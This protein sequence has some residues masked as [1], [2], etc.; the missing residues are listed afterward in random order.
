MFNRSQGDLPMYSSLNNNGNAN[1]Y[2]EKSFHKTSSS[3]F[4]SPSS[5]YA[6]AARYLR[7]ILQDN[8]TR[9]VFF[10][11][12][13]NLSFTVVEALW[14]FWTNSLGLTSDAVHMLFDS[15]A[16][17][18]SLIASVIAKWE[19]NER[20]TYG[21]G[22]VE[23]LTGF[24]NAILLCYASIQI[25][26]EAFERM[27]DPPKLETDQLL[28]V[29]ILGLIVNLVGIFAFD[30]GHMHGHSHGESN[31][32]SHSHSHDWGGGHSHGHSHH[33]HES[34]G[35][36]MHSDN[37]LLEGM[38]LHILS[39]TLGSVGVIVSTLLIRYFDWYWSDPLCSIFIGILTLL[40]VWALLRDSA[41][42]LCQRV[43]PKFE[44]KTPDLYRA[45]MRIDGVVGCSS[46]HF[47][48][49]STGNYVGT[50]KVQVT[51][52]ANE[53]RTRLLVL[54]AGQEILGL[55][56]MTVQIEKDQVMNL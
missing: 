47:W 28:I 17:L 30:H 10:F 8:R 15:S 25:L 43:P 52:Y 42:T 34:R 12:C 45:V 31:G 38:F 36:H 51:D 19:P 40:S 39:D 29:S 23:V 46:A 14:G 37:P 35:G 9:K 21:Y 32:H 50:I 48:E 20:F 1:G 56:N 41:L 33:G 53:Q 2:Y 6:T 13:L 18:I 5:L 55:R 22:R 16:I 49:L 24:V 4:A 11:M 27:F 26:W 7:T 3:H 44:Y 54:N